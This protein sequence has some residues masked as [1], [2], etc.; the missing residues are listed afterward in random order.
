MFNIVLKNTLE[1]D[2]SGY[3]IR[4]KEDLSLNAGSGDGT[5]KIKLSII[6]IRNGMLLIS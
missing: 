1:F 4:I 3:L 6:R 5:Y 2:V